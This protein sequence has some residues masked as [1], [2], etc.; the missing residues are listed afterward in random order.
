[1]KRERSLARNTV[2]PAQSQPVPVFQRETLGAGHRI[3]GPAVVVES[4]ATTWI[5]P[6][7]SALVDPLGNLRMGRGESPPV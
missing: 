6:G 2:A 4:V 5:A 7:W 3:D 1:M